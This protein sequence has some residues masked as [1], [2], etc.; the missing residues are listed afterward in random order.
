M[1]RRWCG[2]RGVTP[3]FAVASGVLCVFLFQA[4]SPRLR[5]P[6]VQTWVREKDG[7]GGVKWRES[8]KWREVSLRRLA[9]SLRGGGGAEERLPE[10][11]QEE[12]ENLKHE[13]EK[14]S[15]EMPTIEPGPHYPGIDKVRGGIL[16]ARVQ[17]IKK[18]IMDIDVDE[19]R[20]DDSVLCDPDQYF[21]MSAMPARNE[22]HFKP[23]K[24]HYCPPPN[25]H[26][27][28]DLPPVDMIPDD[29]NGFDYDFEQDSLE[30][31]DEEKIKTSGK[32]RMRKNMGRSRVLTT[33]EKERIYEAKNKI[34]MGLDDLPPDARAT[35]QAYLDQIGWKMEARNI[36]RANLTE[37]HNIYKTLL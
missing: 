29:V 15:A 32:E 18:D 35:M 17:T 8:V 25:P 28:E 23:E 10:L 21:N 7:D 27:F 1:R 5:E 34:Q 9:I 14:I 24:T 11:T 31:G 19:T 36:E 4:S 16:P 13:I 37:C 22:E 30:S 2:V 12:I 20:L 33:E 26:A 3:A 6:F